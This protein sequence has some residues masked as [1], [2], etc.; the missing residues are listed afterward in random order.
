VTRRRQAEDEAQRQR[1]VLAH[2]LRVTT[3]GEL[4]ASLAHEI[5][6]PLAAIVTNAQAAIRLLDAGRAATAEIREALGDVASDGKRA[7][8]IIRRLRA[9]F[10][11]EHVPSQPLDANDLVA[12]AVSFVRYDFRRK[13]IV[14]DTIYEAGLPAVAADPVQLQQ[15]LLNLLLNASE[16]IAAAAGDAR[17]IV[18]RTAVREQHVEIAIADNGIGVPPMGLETMFER[19]VT[20]KSDGLGMGLAIS[21]SIVQAHGGRIWASANVD[22]GLTVHVALPVMPA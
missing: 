8:E 19:F 17:V 18:V 7:S 12:D 20:T 21:R 14:I 10:R 6:Q 3:L 16:A 9:L 1:E 13:G 2:T 15:V 11:K 22:R 5:N 4:A